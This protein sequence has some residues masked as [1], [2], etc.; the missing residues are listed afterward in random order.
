MS[1]SRSV[2]DLARREI[3]DTLA[4]FALKASDLLAFYLF[5]PLAKFHD[6]SH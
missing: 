5:D 2:G 1:E 6:L 3:S 4:C